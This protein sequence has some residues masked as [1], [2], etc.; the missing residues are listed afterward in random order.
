M[1]AGVVLAA[2]GATLALLTFAAPPPSWRTVDHVPGIVDVAGP[3]ADGRLVMSTH[4]GLFLVRPGG[5]P[6][7]FANPGYPGAVGEPYVALIPR[8]TVTGARC[9]FERDDVFALDPSATPGVVHITANG[10]TSR[11]V[12]L[13]AGVFPSGIAF[14]ATGRFDHRLLVTGVVNS[15]TTL[16]AISCGGGITTVTAGAPRVEGGIVVAP[17]SFGH[18]GRDLIAADETTGTIYAFGPRGAVAHLADSGVP[19]GGD[20][21][22][23]ALG[24]VPRLSAHGAAYLADLGAP[25]S[26]TQGTDSLLTLSRADFARGGVRP[27]DLLAASEGGAATIAVHC[28]KPCTVRIIAQGPATTHA[29][30]HLAFTGASGSQLRAPNH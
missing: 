6:T 20:V 22:V 29:E 25:G 27:G 1:A 10:Q 7:A 12:N 8:T 21:G 11:L 23:E 14:D 4:T 3:R 5:S 28:G 15:K 24:F 13:P 26:P 9:S 16:Y 19:F 2:A 17:P 18:F 30:G